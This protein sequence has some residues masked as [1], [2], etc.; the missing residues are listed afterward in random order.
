MAGVALG[1]NNN[2]GVNPKEF[3][4][5]KVDLKDV[6]E[7][8]A[9]IEKAVAAGRAEVSRLDDKVS[10]GLKDQRER[11]LVM[12]TRLERFEI[13]S[14]G[15]G[16]SIVS[17]SSVTTSLSDEERIA[18][19]V[20]KALD[21]RA[22]EEER[23]RREEEREDARWRDRFAPIV[24]EI[25]SVKESLKTPPKKTMTQKDIEDAIQRYVANRHPGTTVDRPRKLEK[26]RFPEPKVRARSVFHNPVINDTPYQV[27]ACLPDASWCRPYYRCMDGSVIITPGS[28]A[29]CPPN[30]SAGWGL[31]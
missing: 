7:K 15:R 11:W 4:Q 13:P 31:R 14:S 17:T 20:K 29:P 8:E 24:E 10:A 19:A 1:C 25:R 18:V 23:I 2:N 27:W 12:D 28:P 16:A 9:K 6:R 3:A 5:V 21:D 22:A 26:G 30:P